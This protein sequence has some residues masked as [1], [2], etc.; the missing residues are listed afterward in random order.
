MGIS[1]LSPVSVGKAVSAAAG[2]QSTTDKVTRASA[3][4]RTYFSE[5]AQAAEA[6]ASS[7]ER[8]ASDEKKSYAE[9]IK[10]QTEKIDRLFSK[11]EQSSSN[12][13]QLM[14][15]KQKIR[16][17]L[18][19]SIAE[20]QYL[21]KKDPDSYSNYRTVQDSRRM[22]RAQLSCCR[23]KDEVNGMRLSNALAALSS[24]KKAIKHG[25]D[26]S[27]VAGLNMAL[28]REISSF[29][30]SARYRSLPTA[31]E[32]DKYYMEL[33]KARKFEREKREAQRLNSRS[34]KKKQ[35]KQPGDGKRTVAQVENSALGRKVRNAGKGGS[36]G[37]CFSSFAGS[38]YKK[39]D[40]KG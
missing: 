13:K 10:E 33:A 35:V 15:I 4:D 12:N 26:G 8:K 39:M 29:S 22:F 37:V 17:G 38:S 16:S 7:A 24:Y 19:L 14:S 34:K 9:L 6:S 23:T 5:Q 1:R 30:Q 11:D 40:Q 2:R 21:S 27:E 31:A 18:T 28:E 36:C 20:E 25:G 32:R 3:R